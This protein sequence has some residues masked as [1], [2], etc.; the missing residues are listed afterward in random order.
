MQLTLLCKIISIYLEIVVM[1]WV[2]GS[3]AT[4]KVLGCDVTLHAVWY[5]GER[6]LVESYKSV[7]IWFKGKMIKI[8]PRYHGLTSF[9]LMNKA[10]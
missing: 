2:L 1:S 8:I 9:N 6:V 3:I 4:A 5:I 10:A 7:L